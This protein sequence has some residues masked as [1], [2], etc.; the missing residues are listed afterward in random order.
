MRLETIVEIIRLK[1]K[2]QVTIPVSI[3]E[4][5]SAQVGDLFLI[6]V[7]GNNVVMKPQEISARP[8]G[9]APSAKKGVDIGPWIGAAKGA[10]ASVAEA[11]DFVRAERSQWE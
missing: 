1:E 3:R 11:D 5:I 8:Q 7:E 2:G 9:P 4:E 10:F 6:T